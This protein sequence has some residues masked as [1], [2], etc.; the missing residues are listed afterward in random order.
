MPLKYNSSYQTSFQLVP[1]I[2]QHHKST[3]SGHIRGSPTPDKMT[4]KM[5]KKA[6]GSIKHVKID[7]ITVKF[8]NYLGFA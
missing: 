1:P 2:M 3:Y 7:K 5:S 4:R 6:K 8:K